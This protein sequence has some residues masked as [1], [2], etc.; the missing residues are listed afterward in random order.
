MPS[1]ATVGA[2]SC[3]TCGARSS[4]NAQ[5]FKLFKNLT[6]FPDLLLSGW[7]IFNDLAVAARA[8]QRDA[9]VNQILMVDLDVHQ[10]GSWSDSLGRGMTL[11]W[12]WHDGMTQYVAVSR[13]G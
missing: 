1:L 3:N 6:P 11:A 13:A 5:S 7:C 2:C 12:I 9:G 4:R 10:V 8:A